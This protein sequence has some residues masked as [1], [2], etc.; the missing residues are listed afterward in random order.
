MYEKLKKIREEKNITQEEIAS[1]LGYRH[2]SGYSKLENGDRKISVEQA[3]VISDFF[4]MSIEDIF[5]DNKINKM[6]T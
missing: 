3:K 5:F 6:T 2:K 1:L 4:N